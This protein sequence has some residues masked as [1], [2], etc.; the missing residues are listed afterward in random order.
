[1]TGKSKHCAVWLLALALVIPTG[2]FGQEGDYEVG[3]AVPP[4]DPGRTLI[5]ITVEEAVLRAVESNLDLQTA[6]LSPRIQRYSLQAAEAAFST[7]LS[8]TFGYNNSTNQSTSQLDGGAQTQTQRQTYNAS[9][10]KPLPWYGGRLS[11]DFNNNRTET[12]N[13]FATLNP[14]F[15]STVSFNYTQPLL[16]GFATD[17]QRTA[18]ETQAIQSEITDIQVTRQIAIVSNRVRVAYWGLRAAIE[19]IEIRRRDLA[20]AQELLDQNLIRVQLGSLADLQVIQAEAQVASAE[21]AQ[22]SAEIQWRN[23]ELV[24]KRLLMSSADDPLLTQTLNPTG[25]PVIQEPVVDLDAAIAIAL[26]QRAD[27]RQ[28]R[29]QRQISQLDLEVTR[30]NTRPDLNLTAGYSLQGVGGDLFSR[31]GLGGDAILVDDGGYLDGLTSIWDRD[32]PTWNVSLNFSYP[33]GNRAA[34]ANRSRAELQMEQTDLALRSQ[35]LSIV[36]EVTAAGLAVNDSFLLFQAAQRSREVSERAAEVEVT[37]FEVAASTNYEVALAQNSLTSARLSELRAI[38][39]YV[40]AVAEF[41]LVQYVG[42]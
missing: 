32:T 31:A 14:N 9:I 29:Q 10:T 24:L 28:T 8:S 35:E 42:G 40:N 38:I 23:Q 30:N 25:L 11:A 39:D 20:Q 15:R 4:V 19:Q 26:E 27:L 37:R 2:L 33:I 16:A 6:R 17:N 41:E 5:D 18:L 3:T 36:T 12:N 22:L 1:M 7:T 21:Q 13:L 34:K